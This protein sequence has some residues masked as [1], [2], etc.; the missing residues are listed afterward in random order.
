[1][2]NL[3]NK[4]IV[5]VSVFGILIAGLS[6]VEKQMRRGS[7]YA[8]Q[9]VQNNPTTIGDEKPQ[10]GNPAKSEPKG[11]AGD[12]KIGEKR[13][14]INE[15]VATIS[16]FVSETITFVDD[17]E[18]FFMV[19]FTAFLALFTWRLY[20]ATAGLANAERP[21]LLPERM[22]VPG[23][24]NLDGPDALT[25]DFMIKN[26]GRSPALLKR[27]AITSFVQPSLPRWIKFAQYNQIHLIVAP[28][29]GF[30]PVGRWPIN[31]S[32]TQRALVVAGA[33]KFYLVG[34]IVYSGISGD[35]HVTN[36]AY[37]FVPARDGTGETFLACGP[38]RRWR[39][40]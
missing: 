21:Q 33:T 27:M 35:R 37:E 30:S 39:Y 7:Q 8:P 4:I 11:N 40:S 14:D 1:M 25:L 23:L 2:L 18:G 28:E 6:G 31:I 17:H 3:R 34:R 26:C 15:V 29:K 13:S 19:L 16:D 12:Q 20:N 36:F 10:A 9:N 38:R 32:K 5:L 24:G 22:L